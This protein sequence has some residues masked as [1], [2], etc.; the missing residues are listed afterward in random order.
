MKKKKDILYMFLGKNELVYSGIGLKFFLEHMCDINNI[1]LIES[2]YVGEKAFK[3]FELIEGKAQIQEFVSYSENNPY[4]D[5]CFVDYKDSESLH[6]LS[7]QQL[8]ELLY[9]ARMYKP[10]HS[11]DFNEI[12]NNMVYLSHDNGFYGKIYCQRQMDLVSVICA[13]ICKSFNNYKGDMNLLVKNELISVMEKGVCIDFSDIKR[14]KSFTEIPIY[15]LGLIDDMDFI[16]NNIDK[17]KLT[18]K[19]C[20]ILLYEDEWSIKSYL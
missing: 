19:V 20:G 18:K 5:I 10:L 11:Y 2:E 17:I 7:E 15:C 3:N 8:A 4:G 12:G 13:R 6:K 9:L 1:M 16:Y 14:L